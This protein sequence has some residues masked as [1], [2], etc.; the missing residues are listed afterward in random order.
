M[1]TSYTV[2]LTA[3]QEGV[4]YRSAEGVYRFDV[5]LTG[6]A[7]ELYLPCSRGD[8]HAPYELTEAEEV[9]ILPRIAHCLAHDRV[10]GVMLRTYPVRVVRRSSS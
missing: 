5:L 8:T 10:L 2:R 4:E 3:R 6:G 9:E 7:W 1:S